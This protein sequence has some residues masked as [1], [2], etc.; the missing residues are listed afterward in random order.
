MMEKESV[1]KNKMLLELRNTNADS[2]FNECLNK[3]RNKYNKWFSGILL[4]ISLVDIMFQNFVFEKIKLKIP[5][6]VVYIRLCTSF[7]IASFSFIIFILGFF[8]D[9][10]KFKIFVSFVNFILFIFP[11]INFRD[12]LLRGG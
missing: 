3:Q 12:T 11:F 7:V 6:D 4:M 8:I 9:N 5:L 1:F 2:G 10:K